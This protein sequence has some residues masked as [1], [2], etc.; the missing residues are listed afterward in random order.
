MHEIVI[1][2]WG[3][4]NCDLQTEL[5]NIELTQDIIICCPYSAPTA[6]LDIEYDVDDFIMR[7]RN[8]L[9]PDRDNTYMFYPR[10]KII[11]PNGL[12]LQTNCCIPGMHMI[13][14]DIEKIRGIEL[15]MEL[16]HNESNIKFEISAVKGEYTFY[17]KMVFYL[18]EFNRDMFLKGIGNRHGGIR[19]PNDINIMTMYFV[20]TFV[21]GERPYFNEV[22]IIR[23]DYL[24]SRF[25]D[26]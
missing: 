18:K 7:S 8:D 14:K 21:G 24:Y 3:N 20:E 12:Y 1:D 26:F 22:Y 10:A 15:N 6:P 17:K 25:P 11:V 13:H 2:E 23:S 9:R 4:V 19:I 5:C 16:P